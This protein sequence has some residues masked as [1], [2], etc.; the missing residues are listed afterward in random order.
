MPYISGLNDGLRHSL[1]RYMN[2]DRLGPYIS[3]DCKGPRGFSG[4]SRGY[5]VEF[6]GQYPQPGTHRKQRKRRRPYRRSHRIRAPVVACLSGIA[7]APQKPP[8]KRRHRSR[9]YRRS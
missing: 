3:L 6:V 8:R 4:G 1:E 9:K 7:L 5:R 2:A